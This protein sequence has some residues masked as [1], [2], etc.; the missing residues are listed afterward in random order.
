MI[1]VHCRT[2]LDYLREQW[3]NKMVALPRIGDRVRSQSGVS[4]KVCSVT[5]CESISKDMSVGIEYYVEVEL[6]R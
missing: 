5:H 2:N 1:L 3:P 4:L 6:T